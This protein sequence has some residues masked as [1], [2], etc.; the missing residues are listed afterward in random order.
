[1][2]IKHAVMSGLGVSILSAHTLVFGGK[3]GL[4]VLNVE[5]L[6]IATHWYF[7]WQREKPLSLIT[8]AFLNHVK[9]EGKSKLLRELQ[10]MGVAWQ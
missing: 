8:E 3:A 6:P 10:R 4:S 5:S 7:V 1:E 9:D 2:A